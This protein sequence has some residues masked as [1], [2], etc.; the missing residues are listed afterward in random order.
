MRGMVDIVMGV[1]RNDYR[2]VIILGMRCPVW[3]FSMCSS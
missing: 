1:M 2:G 3:S